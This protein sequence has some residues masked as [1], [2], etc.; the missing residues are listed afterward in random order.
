MQKPSLKEAVAD[1]RRRKRTN[2]HDTY[3]IQ[4][5]PLEQRKKAELQEVPTHTGVILSTHL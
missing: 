2:D 3:S 1:I 5:I 4:D